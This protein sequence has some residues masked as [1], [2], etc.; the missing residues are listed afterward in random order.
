MSV[1]EKQRFPSQSVP[2][3]LICFEHDLLDESV[4]YRLFRSKVD[5]S[6]ATAVNSLAS[7]SALTFLPSNFNQYVP[8][9][10]N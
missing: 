4:G 2:Q 8:S 5:C 6:I 9:L 7:Q 10:E 3:L 1:G